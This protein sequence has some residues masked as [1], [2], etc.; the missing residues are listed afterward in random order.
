MAQLKLCPSLQ[1][2]RKT[3]PS[4]SLDRDVDAAVPFWLQKKRLPVRQPFFRGEDLLWD[5]ALGAQHIAD[6]PVDLGGVAGAL[7][8]HVRPFLAGVIKL[9]GVQQVAGLHDALDRVA[10]VVSQGT[11]LLAQVQWDF[12]FAGH[13]CRWGHLGLR[14]SS[15]VFQEV[16]LGLRPRLEARVAAKVVQTFAGGPYLAPSRVPLA[17]SISA[18][19]ARRTSARRAAS[20]SASG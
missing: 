4:A 7:V 19:W 3:F 12:L 16:D 14:H 13:L 20:A 15:C 10:E 5:F 11:Q 6:A 2:L 9:R 18:A 1:T 17:E 8:D